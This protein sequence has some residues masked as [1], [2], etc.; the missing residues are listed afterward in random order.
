EFGAGVDK[1]MQEV[2]D[3][4]KISA[5]QFEKW[6]QAIAGGGENG[7][8]AMLEATKALAGVENAT[9]RNALGTKMFGT[10]WEDQ[11]KKIIDTILKAEGKQV[12]L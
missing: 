9:D 8:K 2:L 12:D 1:S 5:D 10:L 7:Q 6:G 11:G 3:K 4:T